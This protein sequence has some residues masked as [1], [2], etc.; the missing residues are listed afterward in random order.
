[1]VVVVVGV[2]A[3]LLIPRRPLPVH[4][5]GLHAWRRPG[6]PH[7]QLRCPGEVGQVLLR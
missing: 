4:G 5:D 6:Q 3:A 2:A 7:E 1:M